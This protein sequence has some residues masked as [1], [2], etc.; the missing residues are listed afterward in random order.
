MNEQKRRVL[1]GFVGVAL[2][3]ASTTAW[4]SGIGF[5]ITVVLALAFYALATDPKPENPKPE[6][7]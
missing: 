1:T 7:N 3:I 5:A 6:E 2:G 4:G